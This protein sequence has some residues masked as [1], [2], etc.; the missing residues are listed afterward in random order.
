MLLKNSLS[1]GKLYKNDS[2]GH[3]IDHENTKNEFNSAYYSS[4]NVLAL[5][6]ISGVHHWLWIPLNSISLLHT[7][8]IMRRYIKMDDN[9]QAMHK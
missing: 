7:E 6:D 9:N 2:L 3:G 4:S 5:S 8:E 1:L